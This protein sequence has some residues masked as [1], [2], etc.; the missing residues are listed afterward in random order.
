LAWRF[1][2]AA[3]ALVLIAV[4][5]WL[6]LR[7]GPRDTFQTRGEGPVLAVRSFCETVDLS[8]RPLIRSL[9]EDPTPQELASCPADGVLRFAY[10]TP[11]PGFLYALARTSSGEVLWL[12]PQQADDK[13]IRIQAAASLTP[14]PLV[15]PAASLPG[16]G[17]FEMIFVLA[18]ED[19]LRNQVHDLVSG[20]A[21]DPSA[22][23]AGTEADA[24]VVRRVVLDPVPG[25]KR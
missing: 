9:S 13:P 11:R 6:W 25:E 21:F 1:A 8:G 17:H 7:S 22:L 20:A 16:T 2:A 5:S 19:S 12:I 24:V 10:R 23:D 18:R 15:L 3:L 4:V 14:L